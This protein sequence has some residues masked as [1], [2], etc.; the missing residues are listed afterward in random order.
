MQ[1][2]LQIFLILISLSVFLSCSVTRT[3]VRADS[4]EGKSIKAVLESGYSSILYKASFDISKNHFSGLFFFKQTK[5]STIRVV[6]LSEIGLNFLD[7]EYKNHEFR[8]INCNELLNKKILINSIKRDLKLLIDKPQEKK[9]L[10][11]YKK[12]NFYII[13]QDKHS[14]F[15]NE[16]N[17][18]YKIVQ[19]D[20]FRNIE[21]LILSYKDGFPLKINIRNKRIKLN[22]KLRLLKI[23]P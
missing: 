3:Y 11:L 23:T 4:T 18:Q 6:L 17:L 5:D 13:K 21:L 20:V 19:K 14:Y 9:K 16:E 22:I 8:V 2:F 15:Y 7:M 1:R 12:N 10:K